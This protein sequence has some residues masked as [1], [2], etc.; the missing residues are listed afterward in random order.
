MES[1][2]ISER[3]NLI[4]YIS[5]QPPYNLL[6]RRI[7]NELIPLCQKYG[8][9]VIPWSP[10]AGGILAGRYLDQGDYPDGSRAARSESFRMRVTRRANQVAVRLAQ[11]AQ[12]RGLTVT[13][14]ALLWVKD[15]PGI[16]AP[17]TGPRTLGHLEDALGVA[18]QTLDQADRPLFDA[19]VHPGN[20]LSDFHDSSLWMKARYYDQE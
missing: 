6:D 14:L 17:I 19:L 20:V 12:E 4:R 2:A 18:D 9:A 8:L 15:Q 7:E 11:M 1:L 10:I 13:Q 3:T 16:T 5:E